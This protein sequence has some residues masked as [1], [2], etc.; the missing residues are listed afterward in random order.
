MR[1]VTE[2]TPKLASKYRAP[3]RYDTGRYAK[4]AYDFFYEGLCQRRSG[5]F[6]RSR[7]IPVYLR[8]P[9][10]NYEYRIVYAVAPLT[11]RKIRNEVYRN[12]L[13]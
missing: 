10:D 5:A 13:L 1:L 2:V 3:V 4:V 7:D 6:L 11:R 9:V 8:V 12:L